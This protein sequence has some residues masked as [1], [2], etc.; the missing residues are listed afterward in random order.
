[1]I[2][3]FFD[4]SFSKTSEFVQERNSVI[5]NKKYQIQNG[6]THEKWNSV[7]VKVFHG[8]FALRVLTF[9]KEQHESEQPLL[10]DEDK[11]I[12]E[13]DRLYLSHQYREIYK[14]LYP[15]SSSS[16]D[17]ILWRLA[18]ATFEVGRASDS[19][20]D[21]IVWLEEAYG[22]VERA[23]GLNERNGSAH[24]WCA[25]LT[26]YVMRYRSIKDRISKSVDVRH[27]FERALELTPTDA[28]V[29]FLLGQWCYTFADLTWYQR[30]VAAIVFATPPTS[31]YEEAL[32][33]FENA[34]RLDPDFYSMNLLMLGKTYLKLNNKEK[35]IQ[36]LKRAKEYPQ[37][38]VDDEKAAKEASSLLQKLG[39]TI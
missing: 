37:R 8:C 10:V 25:I 17:E 20:K 19:E 11:I 2:F 18:R 35:A 5:A 33:H 3:I 26:D 1:M 24:K 27:H 16:S 39:A 6:S 32:E 15:Y 28:T 29:H 9:L 14:V 36:F 21:A 23:L 13:A 7:L 22:Y 30:K 12:K 4:P 34:E 31:T 38:T